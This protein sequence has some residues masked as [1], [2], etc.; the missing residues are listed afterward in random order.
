MYILPKEFITRIIRAVLFILLVILFCAGTAFLGLFVAGKYGLTT[1]REQVAL[2]SLSIAGEKVT[3]PIR[4]K[5]TQ[6][7]GWTLRNMRGAYTLTLDG[8]DI[9]MDDERPGMALDGDLTIELKRGSI[10][11]I[12]AAGAAIKKGAGTLIIAGEGDLELT[13]G[14]TAILG[15][16]SDTGSACRLE[17]GILEISGNDAG[18]CDG[19]VELAGMSGYIDAMGDGS[20]GIKTS[21]LK[22][23]KSGG[24]FDV[25]GQQAAI[26]ADSLEGEKLLGGTE[27]RQHMGV[28]R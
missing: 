18:I 23:E 11:R 17:G 10:N 16:D 8:M 4:G 24:S 3:L 19:A 22:A 26:Q 7:D 21:F 6:G 1:S 9:S 28:G 12:E 13:A 2:Q 5:T 25:T 20:I 27:K 14:T 15:D